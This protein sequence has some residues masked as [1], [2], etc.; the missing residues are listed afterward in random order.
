M[1]IKP[2]DSRLAHWLVSPLRHTPVHPNVLTTLGLMSGLA[3]AN[4]F[5]TGRPASMNWGAAVYVLSA[6]FD[7]AD[8]ELARMTGKTSPFG[9]A[10]DRIAD[11]IVK[12]SIFTGMGVGVR[13]TLGDAGPFLGAA[14]GFAIIAIFV[15]RTELA[16]RHGP[17]ALAQPAAGGFE[18]ED[19]LYVIAPVTWFGLLPPFVLAAS[20]GAPLFALWVARGFRVRA[21]EASSGDRR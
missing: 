20:I 1:A 15:M 12:M 19:V 16:R 11:L 3:A 6:I 7:H 14:A 21:V 13:G 5:A 18:I 17:S 8:G 9:H 4:L 2:W 10:Y